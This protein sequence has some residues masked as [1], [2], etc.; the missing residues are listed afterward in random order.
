MSSKKVVKQ[1]TKRRLLRVKKAVKRNLNSPRVSVFRS[2]KQIYAQIINDVNHST[3]VSCSSLDLKSV[4]GD[5]TAV[6]HSVGIEL[7]KRAKEKGIDSVV[8]DRGKFL[9][10][11]RVKALADGLREGG[12][13]V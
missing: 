13:K 4:S 9:Y 12:L 3:L 5:K 7:A 6:A 10:H 2:L 8:F 1:R 11:G